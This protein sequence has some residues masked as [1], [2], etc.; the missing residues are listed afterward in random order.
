MMKEEDAHTCGALLTALFVSKLLSAARIRVHMQIHISGWNQTT[1]F[2]LVY[3]QNSWC[4]R[5]W[6]YM[7]MSSISWKSTMWIWTSFILFF[8]FVCFVF[9]PKGC[10]LP[11]D[12][13]AT[14]SQVSCDWIVDSHDKLSR[15]VTEWCFSSATVTAQTSASTWC[16]KQSGY[17]LTTTL[18]LKDCSPTEM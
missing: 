13:A 10:Q 16:W 1:N 11:E 4:R 6:V 7:N 9:L 15:S 17:L 5:V 14:L 2:L 3:M 18:W 12:K 8:F